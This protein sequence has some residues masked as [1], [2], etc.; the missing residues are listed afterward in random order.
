[1]EASGGGQFS[2]RRG[3][4]QAVTDFPLSIDLAT[5]SL[6]VTTPV[7]EKV[8]TVLPDQ[9]VQNMLAA[10]VID[11]VGTSEEIIQGPAGATGF[12]LVSPVAGVIALGERQGVPVYEIAGIKRHRLLGFI[13]VQTQVTGV[14]SAETGELVTTEDVSLTERVIN[15]LSLE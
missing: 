11:Q 12:G 15:L 7:G 5:N 3:Q 9:A 2:F 6:V 8:V 4:T 14:V 1:M 10:N 13:P